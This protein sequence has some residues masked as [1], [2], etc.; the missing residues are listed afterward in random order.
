MGKFNILVNKFIISYN[1]QPKKQ[2]GKTDNN[3]DSIKNKLI[4]YNK[5][6]VGFELDAPPV[7]YKEGNTTVG[8]GA[9]F[10]YKT[11]PQ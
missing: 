8:Y 9:I 10:M 7:Y 3:T 4:E 1:W 6:I 11:L 2:L 5:L